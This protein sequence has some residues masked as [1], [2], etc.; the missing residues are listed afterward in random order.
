M[1]NRDLYSKK[2]FHFG[3]VDY[4][5]GEESEGPFYQDEPYMW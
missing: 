1:G 4:H 3:K 2:D 5:F